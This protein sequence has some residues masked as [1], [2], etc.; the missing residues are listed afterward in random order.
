MIDD[1]VVSDNLYLQK[2][3]T[4]KIYNIDCGALT[5]TPQ[6]SQYLVA[7]GTVHVGQRINYIKESNGVQFIYYGLPTTT[8]LMRTALFF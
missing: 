8:T 5:I 3:A 2:D 6:A 4:M 1:G 7:P